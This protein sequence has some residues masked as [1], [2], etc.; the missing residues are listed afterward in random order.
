VREK[1]GGSSEV[2]T[3]AVNFCLRGVV[4]EN[5]NFWDVGFSTCS[6]LSEILG[7]DSSLKISPRRQYRFFNLNPNF[8]VIKD[9]KR[10]PV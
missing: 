5:D 9:R 10:E 1:K 8:K 2:R 7:A 6:D 4:W 3:L